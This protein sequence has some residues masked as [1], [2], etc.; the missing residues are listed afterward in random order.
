M[1]QLPQ[2]VGGMEEMG[3][4]VMEMVKMDFLQAAAAAGLKGLLELGQ[5]EMEVTDKL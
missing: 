3:L 2:L 1:E 4:M 5:A